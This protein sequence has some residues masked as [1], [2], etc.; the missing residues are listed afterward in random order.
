[1]WVIIVRR[2]QIKIIWVKKNKIFVIYEVKFMM[3]ISL[4]CDIEMRYDCWQERSST[5]S[6]KFKDLQSCTLPE[7]NIAL[8]DL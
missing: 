7:Q 1:M 5:K 2:Y 3:M 6:D 4:D 8:N